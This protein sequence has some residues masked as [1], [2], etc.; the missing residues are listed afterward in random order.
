MRAQTLNIMAATRNWWVNG[1]VVV[2]E[3]CTEHVVYAAAKHPTPHLLVSWMM[4]H[5]LQACHTPN[6]STYV[7]LSDVKK[8]VCKLID[9]VPGG[10]SLD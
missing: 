4:S 10:I 6:F 7:S 9:G 2:P 5:W 8:A 1:G 3:Y